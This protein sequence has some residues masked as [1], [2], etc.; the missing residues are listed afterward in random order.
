MGS[1]ESWRRENKPRHQPP[2]RGST[3]RCEQVA[4][5]TTGI[6]TAPPKKQP[7]P[8]SPADEC[9]TA[10][11]LR[12]KPRV[13]YVQKGPVPVQH[14]FSAGSSPQ[15]GNKKGFIPPRSAM[16]QAILYAAPPG[17]TA[18]EAAMPR[19]FLGRP[20]SCPPPPAPWL[21]PALCA[22]MCK[23]RRASAKSSEK[24][25]RHSCS[26]ASGPRQKLEEDSAPVVCA[27]PRPKR[28]SALQKSILP[29][30]SMLSSTM[31]P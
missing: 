23:E 7:L 4:R 25:R 18:L 22:R 12:G 13:G 9:P 15:I 20:L 8:N 11:G 16:C 26:D 10:R 29:L 6:Q 3:N 1:S 30:F 5:C 28:A 2:V 24:T 19:R 27:A 21:L 31:W 17:H 14:G